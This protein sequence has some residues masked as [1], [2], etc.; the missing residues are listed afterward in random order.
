MHGNEKA[1]Y[2]IYQLA[3]IFLFIL[4]LFHKIKTDSTWFSAGLVFYFMGIILYAAAVINFSRPQ[5]NGLNTA[6]LYR[7]SRNPMYVTLF[8]C[9]LGC[10]LLAQSWGMLVA[11]GVY[12]VSAHWI[13]RAEERWCIRQFGEEYLAYMKK[14]RRYL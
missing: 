1:A 3:T 13:I 2:W 10:S 11:L 5:G 14:V 12:Q 8:L 4:P 7:V 6:G 9:L